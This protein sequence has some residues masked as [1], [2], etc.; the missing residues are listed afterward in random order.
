M[1]T[2]SYDVIRGVIVE[3]NSTPSGGLLHAIA[4]RLTADPTGD[5]N[6]RKLFP[7]VL[8]K[9]AAGTVEMVL[10]YQY[11]GYSKKPLEPNYSKKNFRCFKVD[12]LKNTNPDEPAVQR[13]PFSPSPAFTIP[14]LKFKD[15]KRQNCVDED[16]VDVYYQ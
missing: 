13:I 6:T 3:N 7:L 9:D 16:N 1:G 5:T 4:A 14:K 12:D 11:A 8:G 10:M 2:P 15:V